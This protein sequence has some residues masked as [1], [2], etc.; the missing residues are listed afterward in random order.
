MGV[1]VPTEKWAVQGRMAGLNACIVRQARHG[2]KELV[3]SKERS[4]LQNGSD[5]STRQSTTPCESRTGRHAES[6]AGPSLQQYN[7][8]PAQKLTTAG[9][10]CRVSR[11]Q[12]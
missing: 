9:Q 3:S 12:V 6:S 8:R 4:K 5:C 2:Y 11:Q 7:S 10:S 1:S